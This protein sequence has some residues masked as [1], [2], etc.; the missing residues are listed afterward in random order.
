MH[1]YKRYLLLTIAICLLPQAAWAFSLRWP[2]NFEH[3][4]THISST[5][6]PRL[7]ASHDYAYEFHTGLDIKGQLTDT[8][9]AAADGEVFRIYREGATD[10][11]YPNGGNV[12]VLKHIQPKHTFYT[13]YLHLSAIDS[14]LIVGDTVVAGT[15]LGKIGRSGTTEFTHLHFEVRKDT[16]YAQYYPHIHP[17]KFLTYPNH[18]KVSVTKRVVGNDV[19]LTIIIEKREVDINKIVVNQHVINFSTRRGCKNQTNF[20]HKLKPAKFSTRSTRYKLTIRYYN[21]LTPSTHSVRARVYDVR[22]KIVDK[23]WK[24]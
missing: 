5:F 11:P 24:L 18:N 10:S 6:G 8:V 22:N 20:W 15:V 4:W 17:L 1:R 2:V 16:I 12:V 3:P 13:L 7:R 19:V 21:L 9:V 23:T 14:A